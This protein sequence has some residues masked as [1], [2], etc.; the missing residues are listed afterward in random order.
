MKVSGETVVV[1]VMRLRPFSHHT[2]SHILMVLVE[3]G[4]GGGKN[5]SERAGQTEQRKQRTTEGR[6]AREEMNRRE[7]PRVYLL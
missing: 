6:K 5:S 2:C 7:E 3:E 1:R 4:Y